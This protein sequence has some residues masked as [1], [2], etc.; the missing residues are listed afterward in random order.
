MLGAAPTSVLEPALPSQEMCQCTR[1]ESGAARWLRLPLRPSGNLARLELAHHDKWLLI[2]LMA[3]GH[4]LGTSLLPSWQLQMAQKGQA[5]GAQMATGVV[6][7]DEAPCKHGSPGPSPPPCS[8][9]LAGSRARSGAPRPQRSLAELSP[10]PKHETRSCFQ[11]RTHSF[12][13]PRVAF[14]TRGGSSAAHDPGSPGRPQPCQDQHGAASSPTQATSSALSAGTQPQPK[15]EQKLP[16]GSGLLPICREAQGFAGQ[17]PLLLWSNAVRSGTAPQLETSMCA[18]GSQ[19]GPYQAPPSPTERS[20]PTWDRITGDTVS[21][22][23]DL[24][25]V[26]EPSCPPQASGKAPAH[27]G[28]CALLPGPCLAQFSSATQSPQPSLGGTRSLCAKP[29]CRGED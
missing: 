12:L 2:P 17:Q 28:Q 5:P 6:W 20:L 25:H 1:Y 8:S 4:W 19:S 21:S 15:Q 7:P 11:H 22:P 18:R 26:P 10:D 24:P 23:W 3:S 9:A 29:R 14:L 13:F 16:T 27:E